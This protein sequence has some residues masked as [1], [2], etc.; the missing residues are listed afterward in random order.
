[1]ITNKISHFVADTA[2]KDIPEDAIQLARLGITDFIGVAFAGSGEEQSKIIV[3]YARKM[4]GVPQA[5]IIGGGFKTSLY[6]AALVNGTVGHSLDYD[7]MAISCDNSSICMYNI[8]MHG[9]EI[10]NLVERSV[11]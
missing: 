7:D 2:A 10:P 3:D 11:I 9:E 8:I 5:S 6:L 4:G 1:M